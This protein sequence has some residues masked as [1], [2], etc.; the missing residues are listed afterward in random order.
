M[1][2]ATGSVDYANLA[3]SKEAEQAAS[4]SECAAL[5]PLDERNPPHDPGPI[6][7]P[8]LVALQVPSLFFY[9]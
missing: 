8:E 3:I 6:T 2:L 1:G 7:P 4:P 5:A 9:Y